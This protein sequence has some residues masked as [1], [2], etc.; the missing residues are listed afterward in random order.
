MSTVLDLDLDL[1]SFLRLILTETG[2][3]T[4]D[5]FANRKVKVDKMFS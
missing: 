5:L 1:T 2:E 3:K 4:T